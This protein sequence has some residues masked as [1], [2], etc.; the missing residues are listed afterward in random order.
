MQETV[1]KWWE[2]LQFTLLFVVLTL[3]VHHFFSL[4][5]DWLKPRDPY[6]VPEGRAEK[7]FRSGEG[8]DPTVSPGDRLRLFYWLGE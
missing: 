5:H 3:F 1:N 6:K 7:V 4:F 8:G 2:R